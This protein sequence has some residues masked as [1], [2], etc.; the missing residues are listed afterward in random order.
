MSHLPQPRPSPHFSAAQARPAADSRGTPPSAPGRPVAAFDTMETRFFRE[1]DELSTAAT[2]G[3]GWE[4]PTV[5]VK[6]RPRRSGLL[7]WAAVGAAGVLVSSALAFRLA[8][9]QPI[10]SE[11]AAA[12]ATPSLH[13]ARTVS[14]A[15]TAPRGAEPTLPVP[16]AG[17]S[18]GS[19]LPLPCSPSPPQPAAGTPTSQPDGSALAACKSAFARHHGKDVVAECGRAFAED[20]ASA[21]VA[22][23][24]A[25]TELD[26]G[27]YRLALAWAKKALALDDRQADA[28]AFLGGAEQA[29]GHRAA[30]RSA[31]QRYLQLS[32]KGRYA[33]DLRA[34]LGSL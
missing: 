21:E 30:A 26:R 33:A 28:Y 3:D 25:K 1:G 31:Y 24:L 9:R 16:V 7:S 23:M 6:R 17:T 32:P 10:P 11:A 14:A 5:T 19:Q 20:P 34:V 22:V 13:E 15:T 18:D 2:T 4:E 29:A 12:E 27:R 8:S